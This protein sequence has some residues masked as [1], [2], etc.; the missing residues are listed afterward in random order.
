MIGSAA[1]WSFGMSAANVEAQAFSLRG[2]G[3]GDDDIESWAA[4]QVEQT[5]YCETDRARYSRFFDHCDDLRR[6]LPAKPRRNDAETAAAAALLASAREHRERFLAAHA[7]A[8][9]DH[10]TRNRSLFLRVDALVME[11]A[12]AVPGLT[13]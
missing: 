10:L 8:L 5:A 7:E 6:R 1:G 9:Y 2:A 11:A 12:S 3:L 13:P 4:A